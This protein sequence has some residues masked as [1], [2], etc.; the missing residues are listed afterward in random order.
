MVLSKDEL[1][2]EFEDALNECGAAYERKSG[3]AE[4]PAFY[5]VYR[6]SKAFSLQVYIWNI[7]HGGKTRPSDEYRIQVT[8][9][10]SLTNDPEYTTLVLGW[11]EP[12][13]VFA[14]W[15]VKMHAGRV[16]FSPSMQVKQSSLREAEE[17]GL[18]LC[19]RGGDEIT[20]AFRPDMTIAYIQHIRGLHGHTY[21][22][23]WAN[24]L[25]EALKQAAEDDSPLPSEEGAPTPQERDRRQVSRIVRDKSFTNRVKGAYGYA[26]SVCGVQLDL[27][28]AAHIV[29]VPHEKSTDHT[30]NGLCLCALHHRAFDNALI[31]IRPNY[32]IGLNEKYVKLL[33][34][35]GR[36]QGLGR[37][38][39]GLRDWLALPADKALRPVPGFL[40]LRLEIAS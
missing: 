36:A 5:E 12:E 19:H 27:V 34:A 24:E 21:G 33:K 25:N 26:C 28:D 18:S 16:S 32:S 35:A 22:T 13:E 40:K 3:P 17:R 31:E 20:A 10:E 6:G 37:F 4:H 1:L 29:P 38:E 2:K 15:D 39:G 30:T 8:G 11:K 7:S 9:V 14:G 23:E